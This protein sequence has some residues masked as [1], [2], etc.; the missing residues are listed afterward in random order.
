MLQKGKKNNLQLLE[1]H[2]ARGIFSMEE[3]KNSRKVMQLGEWR[4]IFGDGTPELR[5][6]AIHVLTLTCSSSVFS[7][8]GAH[9]KW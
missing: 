9:L 3:A 1:F 4:E 5:R 8:I 6:F 7:I 2:F